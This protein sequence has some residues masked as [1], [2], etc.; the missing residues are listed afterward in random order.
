LEGN[1][2]NMAGKNVFYPKAEEALTCSGFEYF[3]GDK[4][5]RGKSAAHRSKPD[6]VAVKDNECIIGEIKSPDEPPTSGSWRQIQPNDSS[7]FAKAREDVK[8]LENSGRLNP[9]VGGHEIII[10]GQIPDYASKIG[11]TYDL[12]DIALDKKLRGGYTVPSEQ[13]ENVEV[14]LENCGKKNCQKIDTDN[15]LVTYIF[16]F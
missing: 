14:A 2:E 6:Y 9:E 1:S 13:A 3:D 16:D 7:D 4:R 15:G 11:V 12:P 10:T 5:I 8:R